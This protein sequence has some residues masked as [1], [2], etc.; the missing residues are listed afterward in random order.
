[1]YIRLTRPVGVTYF[2]LEATTCSTYVVRCFTI[3]LGRDGLLLIQLLRGY[4]VAS[5]GGSFSIG[6]RGLHRMLPCTTLVY[7]LPAVLRCELNHLLRGYLRNLP[8]TS[9]SPVHDLLYHN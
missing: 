8:G 3:K 9:F 7:P 4:R 6:I 2:L 1:M 5:L